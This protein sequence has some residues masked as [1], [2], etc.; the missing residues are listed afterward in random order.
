MQLASVRSFAYLAVPRNRHGSPAAVYTDVCCV[1]V[2]VCVRVCVRVCA[3]VYVRVCVCV[4][5]LH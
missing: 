5:V 2:C 1:F 4:C 3:F